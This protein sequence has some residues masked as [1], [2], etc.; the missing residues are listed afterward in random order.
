MPDNS[1]SGQARPLQGS[2]DAAQCRL[3]KAGKKACPLIPSDTAW[4]ALLGN[5]GN[6]GNV[7]KIAGKG[8]YVFAHSVHAYN[9][10]I[11]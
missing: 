8:L 7:G 3:G 4:L 9:S 1:F 6:V 2:G 11:N 5:V 10:L